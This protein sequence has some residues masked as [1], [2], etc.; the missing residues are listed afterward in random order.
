[1]QINEKTMKTSV[2]VG[3]N[4][5]T[6]KTSKEHEQTAHRKANTDEVYELLNRLVML[7]NRNKQKQQLD[8]IFHLSDF[9]RGE[10]LMDEWMPLWKDASEEYKQRQII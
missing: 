5:Q 3:E 4:K 8:S 7:V 6:K 2:G 10:Q 9:Q 1:M